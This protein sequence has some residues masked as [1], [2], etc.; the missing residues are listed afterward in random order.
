M[1]SL[2]RPSV[3]DAPT[4]MPSVG[5]A[6][7]ARSSQLGERPTTGQPHR[8]PIAVRGPSHTPSGRARD[9]ER[10]RRLCSLRRRVA[11]LAAVR[12][13]RPRPPAS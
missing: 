3:Q 7:P 5:M 1:L 2:R 13:F 4:R 12:F 11:K 10:G 8:D 6:R 9:R